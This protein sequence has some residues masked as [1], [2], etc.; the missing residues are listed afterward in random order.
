MLKFQK[1]ILCLLRKYISIHTVLTH[2]T[3]R[4]SNLTA[5]DQVKIYIIILS[6]LL[7]LTFTITLA[8]AFSFS[9]PSHILFIL[10]RHKTT[11]N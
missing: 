6:F 3:A 11:T 2:I 4:T 5:W 9:P 8:P 1:I 10:T 7:P